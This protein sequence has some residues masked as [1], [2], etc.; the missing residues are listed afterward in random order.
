MLR[1]KDLCDTGQVIL[2][3]VPGEAYVIE[4]GGELRFSGPDSYRE[5]RKWAIEAR[6]PSVAVALT[7]SSHE[8]ARR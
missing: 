7:V 5:L 1:I 2:A 8:P 4:R 6:S 3:R